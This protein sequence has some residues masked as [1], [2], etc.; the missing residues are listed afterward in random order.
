MH[1]NLSIIYYSK[2]TWIL[3]LLC[4]LIFVVASV[5]KTT[6]ATQQDVLALMAN[7]LKYAPGCKGGGGRRN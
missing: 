6:G 7:I 2:W 4:C 1:F 5:M 3:I